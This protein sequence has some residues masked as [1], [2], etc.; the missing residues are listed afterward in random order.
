ME[1]A[2]TAES[3]RAV[4]KTLVNEWGLQVTIRTLST[5]VVFHTPPQKM[6]EQIRAVG[7]DMHRRCLD[8][9]IADL[10]TVDSE[11]GSVLF[12][13]SYLGEDRLNKL[14]SKVKEMIDGG[15]EVDRIAARFVSI[16]TAVYTE[17]G[18]AEDSRQL[19]E[20]NL[21]E[22]EM[23]VPR[24]LWEPLIVERPEDHEEIE[25]SDVSFGNRI[26]QARQTLIKV[27]SEPS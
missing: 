24:Q 7:E 2:A 3:A 8:A 18:P 22:F 5:S 25:E 9:C 14:R 15:Q 16:Y 4:L 10:T 21:G 26:R 27:K 6:S 19:G 13:W 17:S 11:T 23:I 20:F 12:Y 1:L